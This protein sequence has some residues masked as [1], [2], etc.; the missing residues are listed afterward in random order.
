LP[1]DRRI[2]LAIVH[3]AVEL[4]SSLVDRVI[5][6]LGNEPAGATAGQRQLDLRL[7]I[8]ASSA[9]RLVKPGFEFGEMVRS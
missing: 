3:E 7:D 8:R 9:Q 6:R 2:T 4:I 5:A 1:V